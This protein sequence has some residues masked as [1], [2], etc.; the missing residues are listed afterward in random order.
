MKTIKEK[1]YGAVPDLGFYE[2]R[3]ILKFL[4]KHPSFN[5]QEK[6]F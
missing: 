4:F 5:E 6:F 2:M 1:W 3:W